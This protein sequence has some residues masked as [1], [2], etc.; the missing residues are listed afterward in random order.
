MFQDGKVAVEEV[1]VEEL[2]QRKR[3]EPACHL[4]HDLCVER[5]RFQISRTMFFNDLSKARLSDQ[6]MVNLNSS[7][8]KDIY[9]G[10]RVKV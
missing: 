10:I 5:V 4:A 2:L 7:S 9:T 1:E 6:I 3:C 8:Q